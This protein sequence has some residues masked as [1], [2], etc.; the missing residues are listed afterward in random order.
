MQLKAVDVSQTVWDYMLAHSSPLGDHHLRLIAETEEIFP[1]DAMLQIPPEEGLFLRM[2]VRL[3]APS[4]MLE[5]GTFTGL[6][7]M[8]L[9]EGLADDG[10]L[11]CLDLSEEW[12]A[13]AQRHWENAGLSE[14]IEL[15]VGDAGATLAAM[16]PEETYDFA[17]IDADKPGYIGYYEAILPRLASGGLI[18]ADN[19]L[20]GGDVADPGKTGE[21]L[22]AIRG[23]NDHVAADPRVEVV[24]L[25]IADG[26]TLARRR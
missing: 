21:M 9:A 14:R 25:A 23:F 16:P 17:F 2:L 1:D 10:R 19:T 20:R 13:L 7:A 26:V 12:T 15:R 24:M 8:F 5:V 11:V 22:E 3:M 4:R 18:A 6:S